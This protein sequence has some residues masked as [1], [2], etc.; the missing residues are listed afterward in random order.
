MYFITRTLDTAKVAIRSKPWFRGFILT[1]LPL[2]LG[3][4]I[5]IIVPVMPGNDVITR[6]FIGLVCGALSII[7]RNVVKKRI[8]IDLPDIPKAESGEDKPEEKEKLEEK[9]EEPEDKEE[10]PT[11]DE[12]EADEPD[13]DKEE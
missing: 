10:E 2:A 4:V 5:G 7:I 1:P 9:K 8:G 12:K 11:K 6:G 13:T 3:L